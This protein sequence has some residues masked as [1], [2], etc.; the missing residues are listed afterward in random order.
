MH[1]RER[2]ILALN[3]EEPD[4]VP[5]FIFHLGPHTVMKKI[6]GR[7]PL[8]FDPLP[9][10]KTWLRLK[11][12]T[13]AKI[14]R[15]NRRFIEDL[16]LLNSRLGLDI[17]RVPLSSIRPPSSIRRLSDRIWIIDGKRY[18]YESY[19]LWNTDPRSSLILQGEDKIR[20]V[21]REYRGIKVDELMMENIKLL[22]KLNHEDM[23]LLGNIG[24]IWGPIVSDRHGL[25]RILSWFYSKPYVVRE[26]IGMYGRMAVDACK[27]ALDTG[28]D[29]V[30]ICED[31]G[32][33]SGPWISPKHFRE[34]I[35]PWLRN[36][37]AIC[38]RRGA[39][40][41]VHSDG[42]ITPL[43]EMLCEAGVDGYQSI[44]KK[45]GMNLAYVKSLVGDRLCLIGNVDHDA[46]ASG[47]PR[48]VKKEIKRCLWEGACGG[49][50]I[51]SE[52]GGIVESTLETIK[53][54]VTY[55]KKIGV[56][57]RVRYLH[58]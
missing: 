39:Y 30:L 53:V 15:I 41:I 5:I 33:S 35:M 6:L 56:Y 27:I 44:D 7:E 48:E 38:K 52:A 32:Y 43:L 25:T 34:F 46:I 28:L 57:P 36:I 26:L 58:I 2:V 10:L 55:P 45:A 37:S 3:L 17:I 9:M 22:K 21:A 47:L 19:S 13:P 24:G 14:K 11:D 23:F 16:Y 12:P 18:L 49:G 20:E 8:C 29:G 40:F 54:L 51:L 50:Y 1:P 42:N 31:Y 4:R